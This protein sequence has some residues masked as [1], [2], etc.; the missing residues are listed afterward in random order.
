MDVAY[1]IQQARIVDPASG[2][3]SVGDVHIA[4]GKIVALGDAPSGFRAER[5]IAANGR[6]LAP[7]LVDLAARLHDIGAGVRAGLASELT[8]AVAG[9]VTTLVCP[10]DQRPPLDEPGRV[11]MLGQ[12][13]TALQ[14]AHVYPLGALTVGLEGQRLA[15]MDALTAAGC[16]GFHQAHR[17][18]TDTRVLLN[19]LQYA[20]TLGVTVWLS[21]EEPWLTRETVAFEGETASRLGLAATPAVA[22][23]MALAQLLKLVELTGCRV[24]VARLHTAAGVALLADAKRRG[25]P[26]TADVAVHHLHCLDQDIGY[27]DTACRVRPPFGQSRDRAALAAA[28]VSGDIDAIVSD[29]TPHDEDAKLVPFAEAGE[30]VTALELLLPLTLSWG[31]SR[32]LS[33]AA[34]LARVT[35]R[36]AGLLGKAAAIRVGADADLFLFDPEEA[37]RV[38]PD[39]LQSAGKSTPFSGHELLGRVHVT[40]VAGRAVYELEA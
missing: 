1:S 4:A 28:L 11:D 8:A 27:F 15:E 19:A 18:I 35:S 13:A 21:P 26:V 16:I 22:E 31:R 36:P 6:V 40:W 39:S 29:H 7:G 10:P 37:W 17:P 14:L 33:L 32:N 23:A 2:L 20:A 5:T 34:S 24:H 30:G 3:D 12:R 9:G 25:L 38:T